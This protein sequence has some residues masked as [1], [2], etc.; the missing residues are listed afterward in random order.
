MAYSSMQQQA[1]PD[2][3]LSNEDIQLIADGSE[4]FPGRWYIDPLVDCRRPSKPRVWVRADELAEHGVDA[5]GFERAIGL[6]LVTLCRDDED[7][8]EAMPNRVYQSLEIALACTRE[9][10]HFRVS[11]DMAQRTRLLRSADR[12]SR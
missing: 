11:I 5:I 4:T 7:E 9:Y 6:V 1:R 8:R 12:K 10:L 3:L 2:T